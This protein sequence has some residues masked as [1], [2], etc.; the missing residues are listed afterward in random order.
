[1][2]LRYEKRCSEYRRYAPRNSRSISGDRPRARV[3]TQ[4][5]TQAKMIA[6]DQSQ[7]QR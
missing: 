5:A 6:T 7:N 3:K 1:M 4:F 2:K